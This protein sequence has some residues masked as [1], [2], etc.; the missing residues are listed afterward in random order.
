MARN[1]NKILDHGITAGGSSAV[2]SRLKR[3]G[4]IIR[5]KKVWDSVLLF[6][7]ALKKIVTG[8]KKSLSVTVA[9]KTGSALNY[10]ESK[11]GK[12]PFMPRM[13]ERLKAFGGTAF[14]SI[15]FRP[16]AHFHCV[17]TDSVK[18]IKK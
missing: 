9:A 11:W 5:H 10:T 8:E 17:Y 6:L 12:K 3:T 4:G 7:L 18:K 14:T 1:W 16:W 15:V 2:N 13:P